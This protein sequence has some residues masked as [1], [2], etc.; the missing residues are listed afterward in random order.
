M[1]KN[2]KIVKKNNLDPVFQNIVSLTSLLMVKVLTVLV[3]TIANSQVFL[4]KKSVNSFCYSH[5]SARYQYICHG[6]SFNDM[7]TN[8]IVSL[9]KLGPED[10]V[11]TTWDTS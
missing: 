7:L 4:L 11:Q 9:E 10:N 2:I 6:Q 1:R 3:S 8:D 5:I